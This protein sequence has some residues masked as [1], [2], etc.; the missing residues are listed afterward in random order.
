M[1]DAKVNL[2][3]RSSGHSTCGEITCAI[4][5]TTYNQ[6]ADIPP[7]GEMDP[8]YSSYDYVRYVDFAG[9]AIVDCCFDVVEDEVLRRLPADI[10]L[11]WEADSDCGRYEDVLRVAFAGMTIGNCR[12]DSVEK[13]VLRRL[14]DVIRFAKAR[15]QQQENELAALQKVLSS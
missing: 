15:A 14:P 7:E 2:F 11:K 9:V 6:G 12:F 5:G 13:E 3:G 10:L 8:D 1:G 4:C